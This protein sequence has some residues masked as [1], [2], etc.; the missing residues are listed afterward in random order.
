MID[1]TVLCHFLKPI[2]M[3]VSSNSIKTRKH[4]LGRF[5]KNQKW[6]F[7][8]NPSELQN[9]QHLYTKYLQERNYTRIKSPKNQ[10][11]QKI[12]IKRAFFLLW[13][14]G[15]IFNFFLVIKENINYVK[16][17][18]INRLVISKNK[19]IIFVIFFIHIVK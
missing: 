19:L 8:Q 17:Y 13:P 5:L 12:N 9:E 11:N 1:R 16:K 14:V 18:K 7:L 4:K 10:I 3:A 6:S 15:T 2:I